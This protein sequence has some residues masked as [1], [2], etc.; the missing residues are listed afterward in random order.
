[1]SVVKGL[2]GSF[3]YITYIYTHTYIFTHTYNK[4]TLMF[5]QDTSET[6]DICKCILR[7]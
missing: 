4:G 1:M 2:W 7:E 5:M 6:L 3:M